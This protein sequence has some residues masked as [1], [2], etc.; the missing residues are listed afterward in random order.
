MGSGTFPLPQALQ[1]GAYAPI[2][3]TPAALVTDAGPVSTDAVTV[4]VKEPIGANDALRTGAYAKALTF[5]LSTT[6]P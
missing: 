2:S 6:T 3:G 5:V 1:D 4:G